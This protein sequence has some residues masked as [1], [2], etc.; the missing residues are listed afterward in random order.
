[1]IIDIVTALLVVAVIGLAASI[2]LVLASHF[3]GVKEDETYTK[4]RACLPGANCGA[5]GY[6]GC[7]GYAK[8][9]VEGKAKANLCIPGAMDVV[10]QISEVLGIEVEEPDVKEPS[11]AVVHCNGTCEAA[12]RKAEYSGVSNCRAV[13]L[14]YGGPNACNFGCL[15]CGDC[16]EV[17]IADAI[18]IQDGIAHVD[19]RAC[20]GCGMCAKICPKNVITLKPRDSK[21]V[22]LCNNKEKGAV[23]RKNCTN[24]CIGCKKCELNCPEKAITVMTNL[25]IIDYDKCVGCDIC[26]NNCPTHCIKNVDYITGYVKYE[27]QNA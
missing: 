11:V 6:A 21:T 23:A 10:E 5:C 2:L 12:P 20:I 27:E 22:V 18:C 1:M 3:F 14:L 25:A 8:A 15:G 16:A 17:C 19:S 7:D 4:V 24:A 13:A 9:I 26:V